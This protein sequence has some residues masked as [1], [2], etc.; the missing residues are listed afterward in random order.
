MKRMLM[1]VAISFSLQISAKEKLAAYVKFNDSETLIENVS[2]IGAMLGNPMLSMMATQSLSSNPFAMIF[3]EPRPGAG[4][5]LVGVIENGEICGGCLYPVASTKA[6]ILQNNPNAVESNG[7]IKVSN[8]MYAV[9]AKSGE[10]L[11]VSSDPRRARAILKYVKLAEKKIGKDILR[12]KVTRR[13][14][15]QCEINSHAKA[16]LLK[17]MDSVDFSLKM[18]NAGIDIRFSGT[19][20]EGSDLDKVGDK[21]LDESILSN[22]PNGAFYMVAMNKGAGSS[23]KIEC[24]KI[25]ETLKKNGIDISSFVSFVCNKGFLDITIDPKALSTEFKPKDGVNCEVLCADLEALKNSAVEAPAIKRTTVAVKNYN[26]NASISSRIKKTLP[27]IKTTNNYLVGF[28]S[29]NSLLKALEPAI[30][31]KVE[32][33]KRD[34][35]KSIVFDSLPQDNSAGIAWYTTKKGNKHETLIRISA[36]EIKAIGPAASYIA[37]MHMMKKVQIQK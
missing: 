4:S 23:K 16:E 22:I 26:P 27:E 33:E 7:V 5:M 21:F 3:G 35:I 25:I 12:A 37:M 24:D 29:I 19:A 6:D 20:L 10:W 31:E 15:E 11:G 36:D 13:A 32:S 9:F 18:T 2:N 34:Q 30:L 1:I 8:E 17:N 14:L 28:A